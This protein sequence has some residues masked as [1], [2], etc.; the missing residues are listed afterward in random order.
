MENTEKR[1]NARPEEVRVQSPADFSADLTLD[2]MVEQVV[3][4]R[5]EIVIHNLE[6]FLKSRNMSQ[7]ALCEELLKGTPQTTQITSYKKE[8]R[9][10]PFR[11]IVRLALACGCTPEML[12][13]QILDRQAPREYGQTG[14]DPRPLEEYRKYVGTYYMAYFSTDARLGGNRR[15]TARALAQGMLSIYLDDAVE[16]VPTLKAAAFTCCGPEDVEFLT[17]ATARMEARGGGRAIRSCYEELAGR[18]DHSPEPISREKYFY[19]GRVIL[20]ERIA[21]VTLGQPRGSDVVQI[22]L[23]N[24]A[25]NSSQGS[26]Y[27]GGLGTMMSTSRGQE[28]MPCIQAVL[29]SR[30]SFENRTRE[31]LAE[32]LFLEPPRVDLHHETQ[33]IV[34][35]MKALFPDEE[36]ENPL[37]RLSDSD[38]AYM[39][40]SYIEKK[41]TEVIK[42]NV[43]G[44]YKVSTEMD[45]RIY[46]A[47]C[48]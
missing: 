3:E 24:R 7:A 6:Y 48:R 26:C 13:G 10:I 4:N 41:L 29:L 30:R 34:T 11:T 27:K 40:E 28:H 46:K 20:T 45:D 23:H 9:D 44:Y 17:G 19:E 36:T 35:Y 33:A 39:L 1:R 22:E 8:G 47:V 21:M 12:C 16:G 14:P 43:L 5:N 38:K 32:L 31:E 37:S 18:P 2:Q 25:A 15:T 42:R